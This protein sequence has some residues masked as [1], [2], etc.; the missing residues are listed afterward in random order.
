MRKNTLS[1]GLT[2]LA[3]LGMI[4][5]LSVRAEAGT[6]FYAYTTTLATSSGSNTDGLNGARIEIDA[7]VDT[8]ATYISRFVS[9]PAVVM[10]NSATIMISGASVGVNNGTFSLAQL[11]FYPTFAGLFTDPGGVGPFFNLPSGSVLTAQIN[12]V[13]TAHGALVNIGNTVNILDFAPATSQNLAFSTNSGTVYAQT[14]T[15][16]T[17]T[18]A[19]PSDV[20]EIDPGSALSAIALLGCGVSMM[21]NRNR[22]P[23]AA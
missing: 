5:G 2:V 17:A 16:I 18:L 6:I 12:T 10:N 11:A 3:A 13:P 8:S 4:M 15:T 21:R 1:H 9:L 23:I 20:P 14:N 22:K 7:S 19:S